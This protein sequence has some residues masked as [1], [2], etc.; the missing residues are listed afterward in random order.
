MQNDRARNR[1]THCATPSELAGIKPYLGSLRMS[2]QCDPSGPCSFPGLPG[3]AACGGYNQPV[4]NGSSSV[5]CA[6]SFP[7]SAAQIAPAF[8]HFYW[9]RSALGDGRPQPALSGLRVKVQ[10]RHPPAFDQT[11]RSR[12]GQS[13]DWLHCRSDGEVVDGHLRLRATRK[14][15]VKW[16]SASR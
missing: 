8:Q 2:P 3:I 9:C 1:L 15:G 6:V 4:R 13:H 12:S 10:T 5:L 14:L 16:Q 11:S 7:N